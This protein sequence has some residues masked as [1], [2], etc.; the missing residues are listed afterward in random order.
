M[1]DLYN[2]AMP[3][4]RFDTGDLAVASDA[5]DGGPRTLSRIE[6]R[7]ADTIR[8]PAGGLISSPMVS[9]FVAKRVPDLE[10][11][12]LVQVGPASY[13]L[14]VVPGADPADVDRLATELH[15]LLGADA[16]VA[17][18]VVTSIA[19][20]ATGKRRVVF[21]EWAPERTADPSMSSSQS[22]GVP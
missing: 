6:G 21:S 15:E 22:G 16:R 20:G 11:Y 13:R 10:R 1:T 17:V 8:T 7:R 18:E 4:I 19:A 9:A 3:L 2:R 12:Q 5:D 14:S